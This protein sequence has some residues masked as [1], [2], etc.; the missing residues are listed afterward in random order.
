[1]A[2]YTVSIHQSLSLAGQ[3]EEW[4]NSFHFD[5]LGPNSALDAGV[6]AAEAL[7]QGAI[8]DVTAF[9]L[10]AKEVGTSNPAAT[11]AISVTGARA[12][13]PLDLLPLFNTVR[14]VLTDGLDRPQVH[15]LRGMILEGDVQGYRITDTLRSLLQTNVADAIAGILG[16]RG[17]KN[18]LI[19]GAAIYVPI[20][21]RQQGWHRRSRPGFRRGWV[22]N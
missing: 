16:I 2:L 20:Q 3:R 9:K 14:M 10:T 4:R 21:M 13:D 5:A 12:G 22:P 8:Y 6:T 17:P 11:R 7:M 19:T 1:M 15:Y 18:E